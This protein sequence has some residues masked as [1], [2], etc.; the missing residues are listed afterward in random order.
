MSDR[1]IAQ[2]ADGQ[3]EGSWP[4]GE[5]EAREREEEEGGDQG[6]R[7]SG[8]GERRGREPESDEESPPVG[9]EEQRK[10]P[11]LYTPLTDRGTHT[12]GHRFLRVVH[13]STPHEE[14]SKSAPAQEDADEE[15]GEE[16]GSCA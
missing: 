11:A 8:T 15:R 6:G 2:T 10:A 16:V 7:E 3:E 9:R 1:K 5:E 12:H 14:G 13:K 4:H